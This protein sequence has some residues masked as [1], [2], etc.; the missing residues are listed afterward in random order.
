M[1]DKVGVSTLRYTCCL[2][3]KN[4]NYD[5]SEPKGNYVPET[6]VLERWPIRKTSSFKHP[7]LTEDV[8]ASRD[9]S[10]CNFKTAT[11]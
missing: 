8:V 9:R 10:I 4:L 3:Y 7:E 5:L 1:I 2:I 6:R 11:L